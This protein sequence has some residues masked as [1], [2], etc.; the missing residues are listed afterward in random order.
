MD[1]AFLIINKI[2]C[3]KLLLYEVG[4]SLAVFCSVHPVFQLCWNI[5]FSLYFLRNR[6]Q[7]HCAYSMYRYIDDTRIVTVFTAV[8]VPSGQMGKKDL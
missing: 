7:L 8:G 5:S 6:I 1:S 2:K 4:K 3:Y